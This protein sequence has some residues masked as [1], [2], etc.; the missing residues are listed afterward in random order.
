MF[1]IEDSMQGYLED[2][3]ISV[4]GILLCNAIPGRT[5]KLLMI[6]SGGIFFPLQRRLRAEVVRD[7]AFF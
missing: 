7:D 3:R 1:R 2:P 6:H 5:D 4:G